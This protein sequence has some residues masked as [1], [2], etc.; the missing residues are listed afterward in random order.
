MF[1]VLLI[2]NVDY[3]HGYIPNMAR[4]E[5]NY[6]QNIFSSKLLASSIPLLLIVQIHYSE[7]THQTITIDLRNLVPI[8]HNPRTF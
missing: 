2:F 5:P 6:A 4:I 1:T 7:L 3:P 8:A